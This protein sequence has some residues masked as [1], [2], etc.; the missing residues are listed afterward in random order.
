MHA[1]HGSHANYHSDQILYDG[2]VEC[3]ERGISYAY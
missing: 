2:C 3:A 1:Y